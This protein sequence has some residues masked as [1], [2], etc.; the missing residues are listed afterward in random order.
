M[1]KTLILCAL[2][3]FT[4]AGDIEFQDCGDDS[5]QPT[6]FSVSGCDEAPCSV[7][8]GNTYEF[9]FGFESPIAADSLQVA[10]KARVFGVWIPW[11]GAP[12]VN[13]GTDITCPLVAG[14]AYTLKSSLT[15]PGIAPSIS[16]SVQFCLQNAATSETVFCNRF[17]V[18]VV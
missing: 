10:I 7:E 6:S 13:C 5:N 8:R 12:P 18:K 3:S 2:V 16:T 1:I 11:P 14:Q 17:P 9:A 15:I 4:F